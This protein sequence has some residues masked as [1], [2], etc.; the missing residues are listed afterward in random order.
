[1][2][3]CLFVCLIGVDSLIFRFSYIL[4]INLVRCV[5]DTDSIPQPLE[6]CDLGFLFILLNASLAVQKFFSFMKFL[7]YWANGVLF[8]KFSPKPFSFR[9]LTSR[10]M[11]FFLEVSMFYVS[12][13][14]F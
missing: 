11:F 6:M 10:I 1:M 7:H 9:V 12:G 5:A 3:F 14:G 13:L 4:E 8:K 2:Y